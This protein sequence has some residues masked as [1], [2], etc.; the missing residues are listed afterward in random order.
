MNKFLD[1]GN[2]KGKNFNEY[3]DWYKLQDGSMTNAEQ[4]KCEQNYLEWCKKLPKIANL[5]EMM[6]MVID[7]N[8]TGEF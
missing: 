5:F 4:I 6:F 1:I 3:M 8:N 2:E 7:A